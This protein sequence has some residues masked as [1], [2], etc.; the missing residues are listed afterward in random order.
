MW[1]WFSIKNG[2]ANASWEYILF[3]DADNST[4]IENFSKLE[5]YL[6]KYDV[7]IW[8]RHLKESEIWRKQP[9]H[10]RIVWRLGNKLINLLL[11]KW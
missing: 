3:T 9:I 8:S 7:I 11:I 10:R 2:V 4:P 1:K 6:E 5:K